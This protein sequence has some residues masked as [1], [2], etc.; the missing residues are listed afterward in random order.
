MNNPLSK[1]ELDYWYKVLMAVGIVIFIL[2]G[3]GVLS[4]FPTAPTAFISLG[5]FFV[6]LGEWTN[7]P[8]QTVL[9]HGGVMTSHPRNPEPIGT[10]FDILGGCLIIFGSYKFFA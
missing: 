9:V 10:A 8:L 6:G 1:L 7:H 4:A 5:V 2:S 3:T